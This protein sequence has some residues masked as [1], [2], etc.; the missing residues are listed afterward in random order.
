VIDR[1]GDTRR[2]AW[3]IL[4]LGAVLLFIGT[5]RLARADSFT[6]TGGIIENACCF[7]NWFLSGPNIATVGGS[8][9]TSLGLPFAANPRGNT[10]SVMFPHTQFLPRC[11]GICSAT[12][13]G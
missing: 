4:A 3:M 8:E 6:L 7:S 13:L 1:I 12:T 5:T 10:F 9:A 11:A 2:N